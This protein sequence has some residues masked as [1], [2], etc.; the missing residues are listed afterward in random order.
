MSKWISVKHRLP[1]PYTY[2]IVLA[3]NPGT[4][5]PKP[6]QFAR[7]KKERVFEFC[8]SLNDEGDYGVWIDIS[9]FMESKDITHWM[10][11]PDLPTEFVDD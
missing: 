11:L 6:I 4:G 7:I 9:Y 10:P 3:N 5:E 2:V 8:N 1:E